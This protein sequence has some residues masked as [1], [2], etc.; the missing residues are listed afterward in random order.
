MMLL[1][2]AS[3]APNMDSGAAQAAATP[4]WVPI[5][6]ILLILLMLL[7]GLTRGNVKDENRPETADHVTTD[8][9]HSTDT[10]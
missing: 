8:H 1:I 2:L 9:G 10:H 3:L 4:L 5:A 6:L 7:W